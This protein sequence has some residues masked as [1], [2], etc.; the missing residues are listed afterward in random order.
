M[1]MRDYGLDFDDALAV[2][3]LRALSWDTIVSYDAHFDSV[4]WIHRK[5]AEDL[6]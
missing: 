6:L 1:A 2:Q 3:A 5:T 4:D